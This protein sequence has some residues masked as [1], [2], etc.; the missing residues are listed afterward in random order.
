MILRKFLIA[1]AAAAMVCTCAAGAMA[2]QPRSGGELRYGTFTEISGIDPHVYTG[3]SA[4]VV[5]TVLYEPLLTFDESGKLIPGLAEEWSSEGA[6]S[7]TFKLRK[8]IKFHQGQALTARD[9]KYSLERILDPATGASLRSSFAGMT[10]TVVDD[11]TVKIEKPEPDGTL[12]TNLAQT[13]AAILS[14]EWMKTN[15]NIKVQ[16]NG[17]G[18]FVLQEHEPKVRIVAKKNPNYWR[19][20][21]PRLDRV[22]FQQ[23]PNGDARVNALRTGAVDM[24]EF[25]QWKDIDTL[26]N[27]PGIQVDTGS[28]SFMNVWYNTSKKPFDDKRVRQ[29]FSYAVDRE[30]VSK[31]AFFGHGPAL[32]GPPTAADSP[33]YNSDFAKSFSLDLAK[34]KKLLA[35]A[36]YPDGFSF[37][38][39]CLQGIDIYVATCQVV[40]ANLQKIGIKVTLRPVDFAKLVELRNAGQYEAMIYGVSVK[41]DDPDA[42][43]YYFGASST[44]WAGGAKYNNPAIEKLL[45]QGRSFTDVAQR[46]PIYR[47]I[48]KILIDESPW[49]FIVWREQAQAYKKNIKGYVQMNGALS[50]AGP[51]IVMRTMWIAQ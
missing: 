1:L 23:I 21:L 4:R 9:V 50:E 14:E 7:Y 32:Y 30:G 36:G 34:A 18:P 41:S 47:E 6:R 27:E 16:A 3:T 35:D 42:Y 46:K 15:P 28:G 43:A 17:T 12:P 38:L 25:V 49:T 33:Y 44:Y 22:V 45:V 31:A 39:V 11:Y 24:I 37:E 29:A 40:Q 13:E 20:G 26:K 8:N 51:G 48:E 5:G 10:V 19:S 2:Q